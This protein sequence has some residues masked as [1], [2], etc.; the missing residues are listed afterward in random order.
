MHNKRVFQEIRPELRVLQ[1][2]QS[3]VGLDPFLVSEIRPELR[4]LQ[5]G[6]TGCFIL[7]LSSSHTKFVRADYSCLVQVQKSSCVRRKQRT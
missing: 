4:V 7:R 2:E 6:S 1:D 3:L 5:G